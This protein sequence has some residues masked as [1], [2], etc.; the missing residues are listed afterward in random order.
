MPALDVGEFERRAA[1]ARGTGARITAKQRGQLV[2]AH[3][4]Y[5]AQFATQALESLPKERDADDG[6]WA[7]GE[8]A[9]LLECAHEA[10]RLVL[11]LR[12]FAAPAPEKLCYNVAA[13]SYMLGMPLLATDLTSTLVRALRKAPRKQ[14]LPAPKQPSPHKDDQQPLSEP[15]GGETLES[16]GKHPPPPLPPNSRPVFTHLKPTR[17]SRAVCLPHVSHGRQKSHTALP[18]PRV[19]LTPMFA[20]MSHARLFDPSDHT[21]FL[22]QL[23]AQLSQ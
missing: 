8:A 20:P 11:T 6:R 9:R 1:E 10:A 4:H 14:G 15:M 23:H 19:C 7:E 17:V 16:A 18:S 2:L 3:G 12:A 13:R 22:F 5:L 21:R